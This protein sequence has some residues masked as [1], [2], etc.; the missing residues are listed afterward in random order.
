MKKRKNKSMVVSNTKFKLNYAAGAVL[1]AVNFSIT[2]SY[3]GLPSP[4]VSENALWTNELTQ[5]A[6]FVIENLI[7]LKELYG[8]L[9]EYI[10]EPAWNLITHIDRLPGQIGSMNCFLTEILTNF[11]SK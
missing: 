7:P 6:K 4:P 5:I 3:E 8:L 9:H 11:L 2:T 1:I 10:F